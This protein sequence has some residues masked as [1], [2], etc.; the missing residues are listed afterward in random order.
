MVVRAWQSRTVHIMVARKPRKRVKRDRG[1]DGKC[2]FKDD[3]MKKW[4]Q[5]RSR[6][7][8]QSYI[9]VQVKEG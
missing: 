6:N 2:P 7:G 9:K 8:R 5:R 3:F 1:S 4:S